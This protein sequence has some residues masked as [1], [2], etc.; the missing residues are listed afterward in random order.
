MGFNRKTLIGIGLEDAASWKLTTGGLKTA[1]DKA[2]RWRWLTAR[3]GALYALC[4]GDKVLHIGRSATTLSKRFAALADSAD[5]PLYQ[6]IR[7]LLVAGKEV[8]ILVLAGQPTISWGPFAIDLAAGLEESLIKAFRPPWNKS[9][10]EAI[11]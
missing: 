6:A 1:G 5:A 4:S 3:P 9:S 11:A 8:R 2:A 7:K 10:R